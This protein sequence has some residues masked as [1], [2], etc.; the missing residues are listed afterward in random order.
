ML[1][2]GVNSSYHIQTNVG[3]ERGIIWGINVRCI[4]KGEVLLRFS[5]Y[6]LEGK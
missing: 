5:V 2:R 3:V 1:S 6:I 4:H